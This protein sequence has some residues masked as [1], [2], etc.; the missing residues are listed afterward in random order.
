MAPVFELIKSLTSN[1]K[2]H[3]RRFCELQKGEKNYLDLFNLLDKMK[4]YDEAALSSALKE[5]TFYKDLHVVKNYLYNLIMRSLRSFYW[6]STIDQRIN[7]QI[8]DAVLLEKRGLY[9]HARTALVR[10]K[11]LA[12]ENHR[13]FLL[14]PIIKKEGSLWTL[15]ED[16]NLLEKM[17]T[18]NEEL[19]D[20]SEEI[21]NENTIYVF[22]HRWAIFQRARQ[23]EGHS[24]AWEQLLEEWEHFEKNQPQKAFKSFYS[25]YLADCVRATVA[26]FKKDPQAR[27]LYSARVLEKWRTNKHMIKEEPHV[28]KIHLSNHL[29][30]CFQVQKW[31]LFPGL[32]EELKALPSGNFNEEAEAF[33]NYAFYE[34]L[35][36]LNTLDFGQAKDSLESITRGIEQYKAKINKARELSFYYNISVLYFMLGDI[37]KAVLWLGRILNHPQTDHRKD[38]QRFAQILQLFY[39]YELGN[40]SFLDTILHNARRK[41]N[42]WAPLSDW[43]LFLFQLLDH[44]MKALSKKETKEIFVVYEAQLQTGTHK[45]SLGYDEIRI[46]M[47]KKVR[48]GNS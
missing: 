25:S 5:R 45:E 27:F 42:R 38:L 12:L 21:H 16:R 29:S 32:I 22:Y 40:I 30:C 28:Y 47:E 36:L 15:L 24:V 10:A 9:K 19:L 34:L 6:Q 26:F 37:D 3:F 39:H 18:V 7:D 13:Y 48:Q 23:Q 46:W 11:K 33:Q 4:E 14:I 20:V 43:E 1:E 44:L 31:E 41:V 17:N 35:Y 2:G 8:T